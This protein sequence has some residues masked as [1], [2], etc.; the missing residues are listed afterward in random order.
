MHQIL[1]DEIKIN[2]LKIKDNK[3]NQIQPLLTF[4]TNDF[5]HKSETHRIE[6]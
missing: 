4:E 5:D 6:G 2:I 1:K 3:K